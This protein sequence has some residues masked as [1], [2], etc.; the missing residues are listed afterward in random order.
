MIENTAF[1]GSLGSYRLLPIAVV[2]YVGSFAFPFDLKHTTSF[3]KL[4]SAEI[5]FPEM[6][7]CVGGSWGSRFRRILGQLGGASPGSRLG[8]ATAPF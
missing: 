2:F 1:D 6:R 8:M 4:W 5:R 7:G 3:P